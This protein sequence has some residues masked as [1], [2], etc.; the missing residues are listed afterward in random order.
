MGAILVVS[1]MVIPCSSDP[2]DQPLR[3]PGLQGTYNRKRVATKAA[4]HF[5]NSE[6][7]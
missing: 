6:T 5:A 2:F 4:N 3:S 1:V 7:I